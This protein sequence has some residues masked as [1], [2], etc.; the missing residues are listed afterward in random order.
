MSD[1]SILPPSCLPACLPVWKNLL[2]GLAKTFGTR[3]GANPLATTPSPR[4]VSRQHRPLCGSEGCYVVRS[5]LRYR[6]RGQGER[7]FVRTNGR[8]VLAAAGDP[9]ESE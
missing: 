9:V 7:P 8:V 1:V 6:A 2:I 4:L 3:E 5:V